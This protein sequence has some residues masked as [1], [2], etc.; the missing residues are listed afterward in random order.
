MVGVGSV[1]VDVVE[2]VGSIVGRGVTVG[3]LVVVDVVLINFENMFPTFQTGIFPNRWYVSPFQTGIIVPI[4]YPW[5]F[6]IS[7]LVTKTKNENE[8]LLISIILPDFCE[9]NT[10]PSLSPFYTPMPTK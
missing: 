10:L 6:E 3:L 8:S 4:L 9:T 2:G 5:E 7:K 1:D